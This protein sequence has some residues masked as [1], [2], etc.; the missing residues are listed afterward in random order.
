[1]SDDKAVAANLIRF[2]NDQDVKNL[3]AETRDDITNEWEEAKTKEK[4]EELHA[5]L[6]SVMRFVRRFKAR[7]ELADQPDTRKLRT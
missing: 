7:C 6:R 1:M 5:E 2:W 4:R 3:I